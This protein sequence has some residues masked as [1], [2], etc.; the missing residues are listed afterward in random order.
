M[1]E[2]CEKIINNKTT[3]NYEKEGLYM[4]KEIVF[5]LLDKSV[6]A[7]YGTGECCHISMEELQA[8][9]KKCKELRLDMKQWKE[10]KGYERA[11]YN[12]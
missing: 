8:I 1:C 10:I 4:D 11:I 2:Y 9:N 6:T 7:G 12:K 3:L 5:E